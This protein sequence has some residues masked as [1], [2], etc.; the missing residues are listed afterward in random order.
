[1]AD[2]RLGAYGLIPVGGPLQPEWWNDAPDD[3]ME[4]E[5]RWSPLDDA[6]TAAIEEVPDKV[7]LRHQP[8]GFAV[9]ERGRRRT[10][11]HLK[12]PLSAEGLVHPYL[13]STVVAVA[14]WQGWRVL[15]AA[16]VAID[17]GV[18]ALLGE[19]EQGK[20]STTAWLAANRVAVFSDDVLVL[21]D[22]AALA[23]PRALDL[24][25]PAHEHFAM[26]RSI[27]VVGTRERWRHRLDPVEPVLPFAGWVV[28]EWGQ[29]VA[30]EAV[31]VAER[32]AWLQ[33][34]VA[35]PSAP[36]PVAWLD[37]VARVPMIRFVRPRRW[38]SLDGAMA[39]LLE[40]IRG[41]RP[42]H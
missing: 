2:R 17:G 9:I 18:W 11:L 13:G 35:R 41:P 1:M 6:D 19:R 31:P 39:T 8:D 27:G 26:G 40:V 20:S 4:W 42:G 29:R 14:W 30:V 28:L 3:W 10:T 32:F 12:K 23:G 16:S 25:Q 15:H 5:V 22:G 21:R 33:A 37:M 38:E 34:A 7:V 36:D 24:R